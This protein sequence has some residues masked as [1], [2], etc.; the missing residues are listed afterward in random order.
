MV[1]AMCYHQTVGL[2]TGP[3]FK[4]LLSKAFEVGVRFLWTGMCF[5]VFSTWKHYLNIC[6]GLSQHAELG[7]EAD[8]LLKLLDSA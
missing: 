3:A 6:L 4:R 2:L 8:F 7:N 5:M 1:T